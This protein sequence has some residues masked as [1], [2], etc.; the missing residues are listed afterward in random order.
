MDATI[1]KAPSP[2]DG[3]P[4]SEPA[5]P[6][7]PGGRTL[8]LGGLLIELV[9]PVAFS[10]ALLL[11]LASYAAYWDLRRPVG[12]GIFGL[13]LVALS[14]FVSIR[15]DGLTL[16]RR[17][18]RGRKQL[19]NRANPRA[20]LF[21]FVLGGLLIPIA[22]LAAA[23]L[24]ELP[25]HQTPM[26]L[27]IRLSISKPPAARAEQLANAVLRAESSAAR[28]QGIVALQTL[29][30]GEALDQLLRILSDDPAALQGGA[31]YQALSRA[32]ASYGAPARAKLRQRFDQVSP[33]ER[34]FAAGFEELKSE[35]DGR[36][37]NPAA[38]EERERLQAAR[39]GL[40]QALS[41]LEVDA[42]SAPGGGPLPA[43]IM[44]T[45]LQMS[46]QKD[47]DLLAFAHRTA[48]DAGWSDTVR[49]QAL[50]L[51]AK[52][53]GKDDLDGLYAYLESPSPLLRTRAT[54]AIAT[55]QSKLTVAAGD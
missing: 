48:V 36:S 41:L 51:I 8:G 45:F 54:Q 4:E 26:S 24:L 49:G 42:P 10:A 21:K 28:V 52:L 50:L 20:R 53:G 2:E 16:A 22:A 40:K 3:P 46:L 12:L 44:Q 33:S 29:R 37:P 30:S 14:L 6:P 34:Y 19:L 18:R 1:A 15:V 35:I 39:A 25:N 13:L 38:E 31:E 7:S 17:Q 11:V 43:F 9:L 5:K 27:A 55:L 23:N 47:P 32:L